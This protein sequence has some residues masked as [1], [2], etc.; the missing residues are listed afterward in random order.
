M[1]LF[2]MDLPPLL[3]KG[4]AG[5]PNRADSAF[6]LKRRSAEF[7]GMRK[8]RGFKCS[9]QIGFFQSLKYLVHKNPAGAFAAGKAAEFFFFPIA[10]DAG[11]AIVGGKDLHEVRNFRLREFAH[12][13][14][15]LSYQFLRR[16]A[17]NI[18][19]P[20]KCQIFFKQYFSNNIFKSRRNLSF[21]GGN[22]P[23]SASDRKAKPRP[24]LRVRTL[25]FNSA[26][27][28]GKPI[29]RLAAS[30]NSKWKN[31]LRSI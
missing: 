19:F 18:P 17:K 16:K 20:K 7:F 9:D 27:I 29:G 22:S 11:P 5:R 6:D 2:S 28:G 15:R 30:S 10:P 12:R 26:P 25:C 1:V 23:G 24:G 4:Q 3:L 21:T 14:P 31:R 8:I 13:N